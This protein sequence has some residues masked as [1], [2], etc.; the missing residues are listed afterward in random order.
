MQSTNKGF[1]EHSN[2]LEALY[3]K[4][5]RYGMF[6]WFIKAIS[7]YGNFDG[8]ARR[9]EFWW[10]FLTFFILNII[11]AI[12]DAFITRHL[13]ELSYWARLAVQLFLLIPTLSVTTRRLHDI[14]RSGLW[15]FLVFGPFLLMIF[16]MFVAGNNSSFFD[17]LGMLF[18]ISGMVGWILLSIL[19]VFKTSPK[20]NKWGAPAKRV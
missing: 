12:A 7:N 13:G 18:M 3:V 14:G 5:S 9:K 19:M 1:S 6:R 17:T 11:A 4:E 16:S 15:H 8:R 10:F 20:I 2:G